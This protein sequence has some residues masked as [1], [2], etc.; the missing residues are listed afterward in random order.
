MDTAATAVPA[1]QPTTWK[2]GWTV[3]AAVIACWLIYTVA[4]LNAPQAAN[5]RFHLSDGGLLALRLS[6]IVPLFFIWYIA[7]R[8]AVT[9]KNYAQ[10]IKGGAEA[11]ALNL[12]AN[13]LMWTLAY[14][15]ILS[16]GGS[17]IQLFTSTPY[18]KLTVVSRDQIPPFIALLGFGLLYIGSHR[19]KR[20]AD[21]NTWTRSAVLTLVAFLAFAVFFVYQ[22][23]LIPTQAVAGAS[24]SSLTIVP[25]SVLLITL[26]LPYLIAWFL[27]ILAGL[28]IVKYARRV[29]GSLYR[30]ALRNLVYGI[31]GVVAFAIA[32]QFVTLMSRYFVNWN[33]AELVLLIYALMLFYAVGFLF[34][35]A[36]ARKL[37][38]IETVE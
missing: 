30:L 20:I 9:V 27:G 34:I 32:V 18:Y 28:N 14:L 36:G 3:T 4:T 1:K 5:D 2:Y 13:G 17:L 6:I 23:S 25:H 29:K 16:V 31:W 11:G 15:V 21:F 37:A 19:L 8:G 33:L 38:R 35:R 26:I 12:I 24:A 10:V 7:I 22:F